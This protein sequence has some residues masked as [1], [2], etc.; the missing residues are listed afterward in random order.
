MLIKP[1]ISAVLLSV[2]LTS[3]GAGPLAEIG[4]Q[5]WAVEGVLPTFMG[6]SSLTKTQ[7]WMTI[8]GFTVIY[9]ALAVVEVKLMIAAIKKGPYQSVFGRMHEEG[10]TSPLRRPGEPVIGPAE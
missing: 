7:I 2:A 9:G 4:R 10:E 5:P 1:L 6:A 8:V 3:N